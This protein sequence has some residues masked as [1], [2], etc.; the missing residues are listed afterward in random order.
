MWIR[1]PE[2]ELK[3]VPLGLPRD[4]SYS[5][6]FREE[7]LALR[8]VLG[9]SSFAQ[10][11]GLRWSPQHS[12]F[13]Y[14]AMTVPAREEGGLRG[15]P[16]LPCGSSLLQTFC[17]CSPADEKESSR[18]STAPQTIA[19][20]RTATGPY[21]P[22]FLCCFSFAEGASC[23]DVPTSDTGPAPAYEVRGR[24]RAPTDRGRRC[25]LLRDDRAPTSR[26]LCHVWPIVSLALV[27]GVVGEKGRRG[28]SVRLPPKL[29]RRFRA[30]YLL[31]LLFVG[32]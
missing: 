25:R 14:L 10:A 29:A 6:R 21:Q 2:M 17:C 5:L 19:R 18:R 13:F 24:S 27:A 23:C 26:R 1:V 22:R 15:D 20:V 3:R 31:L 7:E 12:F 8:V 9:K 32:E 4:A 30:S 11:Q 16:L 28:S